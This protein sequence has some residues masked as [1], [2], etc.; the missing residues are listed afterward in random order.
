[1][2]LEKNLIALPKYALSYR[3]ALR[4]AGYELV[5]YQSSYAAQV[6]VSY[7]HLPEFY[8]YAIHKIDH[9]DL[10]NGQ[11]F[12]T[13]HPFYFSEADLANWSNHFIKQEEGDI[14]FIYRLSLNPLAIFFFVFTIPYTLCLALI[15]T[16]KFIFK[17]E[18]QNERR[19][20]IGK[21]LEFPKFSVPA[22]SF[23]DICF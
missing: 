1:M 10:T 5:R 9:V 20:N 19:R 16:I 3:D 17:K 11:I 13:S 21:L 22:K 18:Q 6:A 14:K 15:E 23:D 2:S 8:E 7:R 12:V 4:I